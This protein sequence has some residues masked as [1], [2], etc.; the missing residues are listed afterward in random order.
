MQD[1]KRQLHP[2]GAGRVK[3]NPGAPTCPPMEDDRLTGFMHFA[4]GDQ[5]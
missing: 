4:F 1:K 2:A 5:N 3:E